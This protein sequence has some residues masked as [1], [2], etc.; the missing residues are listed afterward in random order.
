M[1]IYKEVETNKGVSATYWHPQRFTSLDRI[2]VRARVMMAGFYDYDAREA[3]PSGALVYQE[4][5][6]PF[7]EVD[8]DNCIWS[9]VYQYIGS[10][11]YKGE[12]SD[13]QK[14]QPENGDT[15]TDGVVQEAT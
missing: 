11:D 3:D 7:E 12:L 14:Y 5:S 13:G 10:Q 2:N 9:C 4:V 8:G 15:I 6:I 1:A